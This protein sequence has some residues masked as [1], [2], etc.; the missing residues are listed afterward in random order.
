MFRFD[1]RG[2]LLLGLLL[3]L[4]P[5]DRAGAQRYGFGQPAADRDIAVWNIDVRPDGLGLPPGRGDV[6]QGQLIYDAKCAACHGT[7]GE[8]NEYMQIAGGVGS[9]K[10]HEPMRTVGSKLSYATTL[11]D[12][13]NRAMPFNAP[14]T[15]SADEV[16]ALTAYVLH[17]NDILPADAVL[18]AQTLPRIRMPNRDG[19]T[20]R[21]GLMSV[22]G[23]PDVRNTACMRNCES[24]V[25]IRSQLPDHARDSH[26]D[27]AQQVRPMGPY[28]GV[29]I[30]SHPAI[31]AQQ[32]AGDLAKKYGCMA[33]HG[34]DQKVV[35]P[36]FRQVAERYRGDAAAVEKLQDKIK[37][38]GSGVW[39]SVAMPAQPQLTASELASMV[40]WLLMQ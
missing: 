32:S 1:G 4:L 29:G 8:S 23:Q 13:L 36:A 38:G 28:R 9:L 20:L 15:L 26:G 2:H 16:Y 21:H 22:R 10:S 11:W 19:M 25:A 30:G 12:Y 14:Q 7:F 27:L 37:H 35:G 31:S 39:G 5:I 24:E 33:C 40:R 17:L 6:A 3:I 34:I 18:D